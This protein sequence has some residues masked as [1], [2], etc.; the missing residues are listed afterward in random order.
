MSYKNMNITV[1]GVSDRPEKFGY[2]IFTD[3]LAAGY[4]VTGVNPR[5]IEV[6]GQKTFKTLKEVLPR[7]ELVITVVPSAVTERVVDDC[8]D[9]GIKEIWM[10]PGS[11]SESAIKK[12]KEYDIK[13]TANACFM[14]EVGEW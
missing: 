9:L 7:P 8:R 10:Q 3:L 11:E 6:N 14:V 13:V 1:I 4:K 12:A 2:R 5:G